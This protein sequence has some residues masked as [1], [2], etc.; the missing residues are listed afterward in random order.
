MSQ[1]QVHL[2]NSRGGGGWDH[3]RVICVR[4]NPAFAGRVIYLHTGLIDVRSS[5]MAFRLSS[6]FSRLRSRRESDSRPD[7][8]LERRRDSPHHAVSVERRRD[9]PYHAVSVTAGHPSCEA[10]KQLGTLRFLKGHAPSLP[11]AGCAVRPCECRYSHYAD[12]RTGLDRRVKIGGER[13]GG[14]VDRRFNHGRRA[15]DARA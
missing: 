15:G 13:P 10:A 1:E 3:D 6:L 4:P 8:R 11:L 2:L 9:S 14:F 12:R 7:Q 5:A